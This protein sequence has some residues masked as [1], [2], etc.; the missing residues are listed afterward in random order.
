MNK[1]S[2]AI[3]ELH[4]S[5]NDLATELLRTADRHKVDH[6]IFHV[7]RDIAGTPRVSCCCGTCAPCTAW[8]RASRSTGRSSPRRRRP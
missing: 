4:R 5:E 2:L 1:V 6:E 8:R 3:R 7:A